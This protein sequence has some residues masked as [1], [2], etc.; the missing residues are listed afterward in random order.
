MRDHRRRGPQVIGAGLGRTGTASMKLALEQ[1][2]F[3][4]CHHMEA[5]FRDPS[6]VPVWER[7]A[8]GLPVDWAGFLAPWGATM[9]FPSA[10]YYREL[11]EAFPDARVVLTVR[12][13][14]RWYDSFASTIRAFIV[15][16]PNRW[17]LPWLPFVNASY[18]VTRHT[19]VDRLLHADR[20]QAIALFEEWNADVQRHVPADR[21]LVYRVAEGWAPLCAFLG[22]PEP[23]RPFP[24][25]N[26]RPVFRRRVL[27]ITA[28]SWLVLA[29]PGVAAAALAWWLARP[30]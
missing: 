30:R 7:A 11:L 12:D 24:R 25:V 6:E 8:R 5:V 18:R 10:L 15:S 29:A 3:G 9:D 19:F 16:F 27:A 14:E 21:L 20:A 28:L 26:E 1:L 22:V 13:P 23:D 17:V 2:G 4:P